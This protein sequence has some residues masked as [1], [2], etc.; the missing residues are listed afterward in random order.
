VREAVRRRHLAVLAGD[1]PQHE[2]GAAVDQ[3]RDEVPDLHL[4]DERVELPARLG[5]AGRRVR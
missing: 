5:G 4:L 2:V 1:L 3:E